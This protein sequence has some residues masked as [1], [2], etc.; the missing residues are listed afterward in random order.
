MN[1]SERRFD[2][3]IFDM[4]G[5]L[6]EPTLDFDA[7]R[8]ELGAPEGDLAH[9]VLSLPPA[10]RARAWAV[11]EA[12]EER[13]IL[14]Q[15]LQPGAADLLSDCR[16]AGI[17]LGVVTRNAARSV[18][19]LCR[20]YSLVFDAVVTREFPHI[21]PHPGPVLHILK[22]WGMPAARAL[23]VGDY[24]HD[25]DCGRAAGTATCFFQNPGHAF[26]GRDADYTVE[27]FAALRA[28]MFGPRPP[29]AACRA[30]RS[31]H[32]TSGPSR[33]VRG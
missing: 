13:A 8:R 1:E 27:S 28:V 12:H 17:R 5:T 2:G 11:V 18:Q 14:E 15:R 30:A 3:V 19:A 25:M 4:D 7:M 24:V 26:H 32:R 9:Y 21:K 10:E 16:R 20:T 22:G 29:V 23:M 33:H 31:V 6:T